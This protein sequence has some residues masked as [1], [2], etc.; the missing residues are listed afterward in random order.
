MVKN[1][2]KPISR[3]V[4]ARLLG[5]VAAMPLALVAGLAQAGTLL[6]A[7]V[8]GTS[9]DGLIFADPAEGV[10]EPGLK[11]ITFTRTRNPD[12]EGFVD[13]YEFILTDF[14]ALTSRGDVSNCLMANNPAVYCDSAGGSGKRVKTW[15]TGPSP[16]DIRLRTQS[17]AEFPTVDYF[18]FG[19]TSNFT[20]ARITGLSLQ[21][22]A[23]DGTPMGALDPANAV[24][25]NTAATGIGLGARLPDGLFGAGGQ[26]GEIGFFDPD[27]ATLSLTPSADALDFGA[28]TN[29]YYVTNF[30]TAMLDNSMLPD[31]LFWDDNGDPSDESALV[32][33][34]NIAGGGWTYGI[35]E[36][37]E[38]IDA[39]LAEL[40]ASLGVT[41]PELGYAA[42]ALVPAEIVAA[43]QANGLFA[44]DKIEDLRNANL[45]FTLTVGNLETGE[46]TLRFV[47]SF[48]PVVETAGSRAQ[49]LTAG[50]LDAANVPFLGAD[51]GYL[52]IIDSVMALPTVAERQ[53]ALA[54]L[55]FTSAAGIFGSA[56]AL[57][58][59]Q[60]FALS[61]GTGAGD[62]TGTSVSSKGAMWSL[63]GITRGF[64]SLGGRVSDTEATSNNMGF[65][66]ESAS[67]WAGIER[68]VNANTA[69]GVMLGGGQANT[70]MDM[71]AGSVDVDSLGLG[72]YA[73]GSM[74]GNGRYKAMF[75]YQN[76]SLDTERNIGVLGAT[77]AGDTDGNMF[78][79]GVEAD[80]LKPMNTWRWGPTAAL[81]FVNVSVDGYTETGAGL[82][83]LT[84]ADQNT[85]YVLASAGLRAEADYQV[86]G[87]M[88]N[89]FAY[90]TLTT[91][92]GGD[93]VIATNFAGLP[94]FGM[95]VDAQD[96][97]WVDFGV[98]ISATLAKSGRSET[99]LGA[100]YKGAFFGD[101]FESHAVKMS[102][103]VSF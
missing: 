85:S 54:E 68:S 4:R 21:L 5:C 37:P 93:D 1:S 100:E 12:G 42:G 33:W 48:A 86:G 59:D 96:D 88:V 25:F 83:N 50:S 60:F 20:G 103:N 32:A 82:G 49:F 14:T 17:S 45:N 79:A 92:S 72:V 9:G 87:G 84:V 31:G 7:P 62:E 51:A 58:T 27:R 75:G 23:S 18:T 98:G 36:L 46:F 76:L 99:T 3:P 44:V 71:D 56:Y 6:D 53:Q 70:D 40:A 81:Q 73:R 19:K 78:V 11:A 89:S 95:P 22:L 26:E 61:G 35:I 91:Q 10:L 52:A 63:D 39:R 66:T 102:L 16:F 47:P 67:V 41:V 69:V 80:W 24:L 101:G 43:A 74:G 94:A 2:R 64:V 30:G 34:N 77:A 57:G 97:T 13:P 29:T 8:A 90:A 38:N 55:G 65:E 15:L 28:L